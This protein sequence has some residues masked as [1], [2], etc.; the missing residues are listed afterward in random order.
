MNR[1]HI[2]HTVIAAILQL[3]AWPAIGLVSGAALAIALLL[4]RE[5]A[6]HEYK[7]ALQRGWQWGQTKPVAWHEGFL[8]GWSRDSFLDVLIPATACAAIA[9]GVHAL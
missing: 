4:G 5:I 2:E 1:T 6:Q 9:L 7:L 3:L 8:R